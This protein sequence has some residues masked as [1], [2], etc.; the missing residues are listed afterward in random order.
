MA[1]LPSG[2][3]KTRENRITA[4]GND[5]YSADSRSFLNPFLRNLKV[6]APFSTAPSAR[7]LPPLCTNSGTSVGHRP[8]LSFAPSPDPHLLSPS[9]VKL[10]RGSSAGARYTF[11][12][13]EIALSR[14]SCP[15]SRRASRNRLSSRPR[16]YTPA[17]FRRDVP[18]TT[19]G[20]I[21]T[22]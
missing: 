4:V 8:F 3:S 9:P 18:R 19:P 2:D 5:L 7:E 11:P 16:V 14:K 15:L 13:T 17:A 1:P 10:S 6:C 20:N 22:R 21:D 12:R